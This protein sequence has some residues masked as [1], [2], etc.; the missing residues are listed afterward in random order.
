VV[1]GTQT[2]SSPSSR[3]WPT[4]TSGRT[5]SRSRTGSSPGPAEAEGAERLDHVPGLLEQL[6]QEPLER[7]TL[8]VADVSIDELSYEDVELRE[9]ESHDGLEF[10]VAE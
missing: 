1:T 2:T 8:E 6:S 7:P 10:S 9:Y 4:P 3:G 5:T